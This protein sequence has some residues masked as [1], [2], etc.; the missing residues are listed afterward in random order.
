MRL[1]TSDT[2]HWN[3]FKIL[4]VFYFTCNHIWNWNKIISAA[5]V[6]SKLFQWHWTLNISGKF[7]GAEIKLFQSDT[8]EG[9]I[10]FEIIWFHT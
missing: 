3:N 4:L 9:L 6:V 7:P 2:K 5:E 8:D 10:D 1:I